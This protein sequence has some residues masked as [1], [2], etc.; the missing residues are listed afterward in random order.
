[1]TMTVGGSQVSNSTL[2]NVQPYVYTLIT[3]YSSSYTFYAGI[4]LNIYPAFLYPECVNQGPVPVPSTVSIGCNL[5]DINGNLITS[6]TH[7]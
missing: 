5:Y 4:G 6:L 3:N 2:V 1:M 7:C